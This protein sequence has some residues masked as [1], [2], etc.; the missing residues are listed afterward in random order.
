MTAAHAHHHHSA[1]ALI[2]PTLRDFGDGIYA[3][4]SGY[5]RSEFDAIH[6]VVHRGRIAIIDTSTRYAVPHVVAAIDALGLTP[7]D[8]DWIFLT[9]V[10]LDHAGGAGTLM[11]VCP[12]AKITVHPRGVR[13]LVDPSK[14]WAAVCEVYGTAMAEREYGSLEPIAHERILETPESTRVDLAGRVFE[15]WDSPGHAKHHVYIR[16]SQSKSFFTGDTFGISYRELDSANGP[17]VFITSSPSQFTPEDHKASIRRLLAA[18]PPAVYLTHYS[19]LRDVQRHGEFLLGQIDQFTD[20]ARQHLHA[21]ASRAR[22]IREGLERL[23]LA[24]LK[25]HGVL[26]SEQACL[27]VLDLDIKLNSD[28]LVCWLDSL[29]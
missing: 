13:H 2:T 18:N 6:F 15:F 3:L 14:L 29:K 24:D 17:Y 7:A 12:N 21:G 11:Q 4:D 8:V 28:G 1:A 9:H 20:I 25:H 16:D 26:L 22:G 10:H 5:F 23:F 19:Q 27:E